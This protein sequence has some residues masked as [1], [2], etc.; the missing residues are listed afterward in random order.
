MNTVAH[1]M[2]ITYPPKIEAVFSGKCRQ[3]I[4]LLKIRSIKEEGDTI[5]FHD[6][7]G[8]PYRSKWGRRLKVTVTEVFSLYYER[9]AWRSHPYDMDPGLTYTRQFMEE[10]AKRDLIDPPTRECLEMV[11]AKLNDLN[12]LEGTEWQVIRW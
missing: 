7:S 9:G 12:T 4:R 5:L 8:K 10:L 6:W 11:L 2:A 1:T 3:T